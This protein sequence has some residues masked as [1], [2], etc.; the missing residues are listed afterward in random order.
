MQFLSG[1]LDAISKNYSNDF[2]ITRSNF[3]EESWDL[4]S[5]K[6]VLPYNYLD[7]FEKLNETKLLDIKEFDDVLKLE[8]CSQK[9]YDRALKIWNIFKC[10]TIKDYLAIYLKSDVLIL[11]DI[12]EC[13]RNMCLENYGLDPVYYYTS[14]NFF[15]EA[16]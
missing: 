15:W 10:K 5:Q 2:K 14:P 16:A 1:S 13:F 4:I 8:K 11:A 6:G 3:P 12:I 7:I 9:D